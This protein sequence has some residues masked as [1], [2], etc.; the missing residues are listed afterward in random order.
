MKLL[1]EFGIPELTSDQIETLCEIAEKAARSYVMARVPSRR[2]SALDITVETEGSKPVMVT[3]DVEV[4]LSLLVR[5]CDVEKLA[6]EAT[7]EAFK[8]AEE[9]LRSLACTSTK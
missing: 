2:I 7:A 3:M 1:E 4:S 9:Y 6:N 5:G 8:S